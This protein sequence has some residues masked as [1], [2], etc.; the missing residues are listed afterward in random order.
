MRRLAA[1]LMPRSLAGQF[2]LLLAGA[3]VFAS[4]VALILLDTERA[5]FAR[6]ARR[7]AQVE[8]IAALVPVLQ[9]VPPRLR[10]GVAQ[11]AS[12]PGS[13]VSVDP[14]PV[15]KEGDEGWLADELLDNFEDLDI[16]SGDARI[17]ITMNAHRRGD[18]DDGDRGRRRRRAWRHMRVEASIPL[19][20]GTWLNLRQRRP[21]P[22]PPVIGGAIVFTLLLSL[23]S[24]LLVGIVFV[25]RITR[26]LRALSAAAARAGSGDRSAMVPEAGA[27]ELREAAAAFNTMQRRIAAFDAERARTIAAVGHDL[28]TPITS[29]RIRA[30]MLDDDT[31]EAMVKTLEEMRVMAEGL[32][33][34]GR[35]EADAEPVSKVDLAALLADLCDGAD[36]AVHYEGPGA[37]T[38]S[39]RPVSLSRAFANVIGNARRYAGEAV[40]RLEPDDAGR[41]VVTVTDSGPGIPE[42]RL[43]AVFEPFMRLDPSRSMETGGEGLGLA[44]ARTIIRA[45]GGTIVL[46]NRPDRSGL[47]ATIRLP[48]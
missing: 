30:E 16:N 46:S 21:E 41:V 47:V 17:K 2:A 43:D 3:L 45:H 48:L 38:L 19:G 24:V 37:L 6:E 23:V 20:D 28:R 31:R 39:G 36:G 42:D 14:R 44:I 4:V 29:L 33:A 11:A 5:R 22:P 12:T 9:S 25:R 8:R 7:G 32:L 1:R 18:D 15:V 35:N 34:Y 13:L 10:D 26:P 40:V 27:R